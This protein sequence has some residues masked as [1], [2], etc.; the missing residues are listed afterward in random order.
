M[1]KEQL[2]EIRD[3]A[4]QMGIS[5]ERK[6]IQTELK[7]IEKTLSDEIREELT[8]ANDWSSDYIDNFEFDSGYVHGSIDMIIKIRKILN[9]T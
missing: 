4:I 1:I 6:R 2:D 3:M 7:R 5:Q 9:L 8:K